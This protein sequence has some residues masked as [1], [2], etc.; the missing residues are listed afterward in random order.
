MYCCNICKENLFKTRKKQLDIVKKE[1]LDNYDENNSIV[2]SGLWGSGKTSFVNALKK[3]LSIEGNEIVN[4][5]C[6]VECDL[7]QMLR[8]MSNQI[9]EIMKKNKIYTAHILL[10]EVRDLGGFFMQMKILFFS[11][12]TIVIID[13]NM[14]Q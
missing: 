11:V 14:P 13:I 10:T 1:L 12:Y 3:Q 9:E 7:N 5:Q 8:N 2:I 4:I 6:G